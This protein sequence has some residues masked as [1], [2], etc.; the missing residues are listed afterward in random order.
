VTVPPAAGPVRH[1]V[2][3]VPSWHVPRAVAKRLSPDAALAVVHGPA[4]SGKSQLLAWWARTALPAERPVVWLDGAVAPSGDGLWPRVR[5]ALVAAGLL[6]EGDPADRGAPR[7]GGTDPVVAELRGL[8][9]PVVLVLDGYERLA[10][11]AADDRLVQV[12][13]QVDRLHVAVATRRSPARLADAAALHLDVAEVGPS[14]LVLDEGETAE[15]LRVAGVAADVAAASADRVRAATDGLAVAVRALAIGAA[16]G[17]TDLAAAAP[18]D[19]LRAASRGVVPVLVAG[20]DGAYLRAAQ[21]LSVT[22]A[23][24]PGLAVTLAGAGGADVLAGLEADGLGAWYDD[25]F[26]LT[27]VVRAALRAELDRSDPRA[28]DPLL[29][30]VVAWGL[31]TG[32]LYRAL[33]AAAETGDLDLLQTTVLRIWGTGQV[34]DAAETIRVLESLPPGARR[35]RPQLALLLALLYNTRPEHRVKALEWFA[36]AAAAAVAHLPRATPAERAVLRTGESVAARLLGRGGRART[37]AQA[38]LEHLGTV[39]PGTDATVDGLRGLMHRQLGV[40]L[41]SGGD[42][43]QG[44]RVVDAGLAHV[45]TGSLAEFSTHSLLAGLSAVQGDLAAARH[46]VAV[47][48]AL[49]PPPRPETAYRRSTLELARTHLAVEDGDLDRAEAVLAAMAGELRTNEFWPAFAEVQA[50]L[51]LLRGRP[52]AGAE[53]LDQRMRRGRR[54]PA[55]SAWRARLVAARSVLALAA[56][57][58]EGG[59]AALDPVPSTQPAARVARARLLLSTGR[60]ADAL[61]LLAAPDLPDEGPRLRVTRRLLLAAASAR[62]GRDHPAARALREAVAVVGLGGSATGWMLLSPEERSAVHALATRLADPDVDRF[63]ARTTDVPV[64]VPD[65]RDGVGLTE[66]ELVV[67]RALADDAELAEVAARLHVSHN[68]VKS[69]AR[70]A[71]RKLGVRRRADAVSRARELGLL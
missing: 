30:S 27:P 71:Y 33:H 44:L 40:S 6:P 39:P 66:R 38:A 65:A 46:H 53:T 45:P 35:R 54:S 15:L 63:L 64:V 57:Q 70:S 22:D 49:E 7:R 48:A 14:D 10:S 11:P 56:G 68:T 12:L 18:G 2:P 17:S 25:A 29:R 52:V 28:V 32:S 43:E 51:D 55:T 20:R 16:R 21:R 3:R 41:A 61:A 37:A 8:T 60:P 19:L 9:A 36:F 42:L 59:V 31:A 26:V 69:Q 13:R 58:A 24:T 62:E 34:R 47:A 50:V 23:L 67:L 4:G 5:A 1:G